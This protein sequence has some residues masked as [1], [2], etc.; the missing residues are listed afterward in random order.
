MSY[1]KT[2]LANVPDSWKRRAEGAAGA[3][4]LAYAGPQAQELA[5]VIWTAIRAHYGF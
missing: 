3:A 1:L 4:I 2:L 5:G